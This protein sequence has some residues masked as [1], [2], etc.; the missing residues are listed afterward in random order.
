MHSTSLHT[1]N[2]YEHRPI[3]VLVN[4]SLGPTKVLTYIH[5]V[6]ILKSKKINI[7]K[8]VLNKNLFYFH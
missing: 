2:V 8:I 5:V 7:I 6:K 3:R 4:I 1:V